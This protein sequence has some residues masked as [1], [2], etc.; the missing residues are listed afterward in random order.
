MNNRLVIVL[1]ASSLALAACGE[2]VSSGAS[3]SDAAPQPTAASVSPDHGPFGGGIEVTIS[4]T[5]FG[6]PNAGNPMV[7]VGGVVSADASAAGDDAITFDLP[8]GLEE[9]ATVDIT[10][11][12]QNGVAVLVDA[13][14]YN[15]RPILISVGPALARRAGGTN[16]TIIG[17]GFEDLEAGTPTVEVNGIAAVGV[18]VVSD[19]EITAVTAADPAASPG[20]AVDVVVTNDNGA[21]TLEKSI[22]LTAPGLLAMGRTRT[23]P[24][25]WY[26]DL[27]TGN[28]N[29]LTRLP[30][31][32]SLCAQNPSGVMYGKTGNNQTGHSLVTF[33][34]LT[35]T[36]TTIGA[37]RTAANAPL[38]LSAMT[39]VGNTLYGFTQQNERLHSIDPTTGIATLVNATGTVLSRQNSI[40]VKDGTSVYAANSFSG[41]LDTYPVATGVRSIIGPSMAGTSTEIIHG[42]TFIGSS[43]FAMEY[44]GANRL[45]R[46]NT[47]TGALTTVATLPSAISGICPT[48]LTF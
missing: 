46:V 25:I 48:P 4:G 29:L 22:K 11:F 15:P 30:T 28:V 24:S 33:D 20:A 8:P 45:F 34:L 26:V 3:G 47:T 41:T 5:G 39:F 18:T 2:V 35:N 12:N 10:V 7:V 23:D 14:T 37:I 27:D 19:I 36:Q 13:F 17:R 16:I 9:G 43:L 32:M 44:R 6:G 1:G 40:A 21:D 38:N 31:T 42:M